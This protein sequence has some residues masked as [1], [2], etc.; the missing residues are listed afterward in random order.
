MLGQPKAGS[1]AD[2]TALE[3][4]VVASG[5]AIAWVQD[6]DSCHWLETWRAPAVGGWL[7]P[8]AAVPLCRCPPCP[9]C[10]SS[11]LRGYRGDGS[12]GAGDNSNGG[13]RWQ[14]NS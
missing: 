14:I 4:S 3:L 8:G 1:R 5:I 11:Q 13:D 9:A 10:P 2:G 12:D 7:C 6:R